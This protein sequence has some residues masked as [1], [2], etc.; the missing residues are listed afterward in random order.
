MPCWLV[1]GGKNH[2]E[3]Y[4]DIDPALNCG[5][6]ANFGEHLTLTNIA[7]VATIIFTACCLCINP[8]SIYGC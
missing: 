6:D 1:K 5:V 2:Y 3:K 8:F 4:L 7:R